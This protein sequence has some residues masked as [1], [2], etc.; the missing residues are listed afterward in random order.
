[1][2]GGMALYNLKHFELVSISATVQVC[3]Y[4][5]CHER[6]KAFT[7]AAASKL[8]IHKALRRVLRRTDRCWP[9]DV[10][11]ILVPCS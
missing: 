6:L 5:C 7:Y 8:A 1:M 4:P 11:L 10:V 9:Q 2:E 3:T